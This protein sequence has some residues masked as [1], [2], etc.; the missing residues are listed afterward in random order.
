MSVAA[1]AV[2]TVTSNVANNSTSC[3]DYKVESLER[4]CKTLKDIIKADSTTIVKLKGEIQQFRSK[5]SDSNII[6]QLEEVR[7]ERNR[8]RELTSQQNK[9]EQALKK[10]LAVVAEA[11]H[12]QS[13]AKKETDQ[14]RL[15]NELF[16]S[17]IVEN[18]SEIRRMYSIVEQLK[19]QLQETRRSEERSHSLERS[20][21]PIM[22]GS[23]PLRTPERTHQQ[24]RHT[25][26]H[27]DLS[28]DDTEVEEYSESFDET[29]EV[30]ATTDGDTSVEA[31]ES[32][33]RGT[34]SLLDKEHKSVE[35][36]DEE[37]ETKDT[38]TLLLNTMSIEDSTLSFVQSMQTPEA[39]AMVRNTCGV[40][41]EALLPTAKAQRG[42]TTSVAADFKTPTLHTPSTV[43]SA[44]TPSPSTQELEA[45]STSPTDGQ[46]TSIPRSAS[47][48]SV[49]EQLL[50]LTSRLEA[51]EKERQESGDNPHGD[52]FEVSV[53]GRVVNDGS[54]KD[55][56]K[57]NQEMNPTSSWGGLCDCLLHSHA[58]D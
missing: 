22:G 54:K 5:Y 24:R 21:R 11:S 25:L 31:E 55:T 20:W 44:Q 46:R 27:Y 43:G 53:G 58:V 14:L 50:A 40:I 41:F 8:L 10:E 57:K 39:A 9:K 15:E 12:A 28:V 51:L 17:Q 37:L 52:G 16:A 49:E 34:S 36:Q 7:N 13:M 2:T 1:S 32:L 26:E 30:T 47:M 29:T 6:A 38:S 35:N 4:E 19:E 3:L 56:G 42:A 33:A 48:T 23:T 45:L 18:E